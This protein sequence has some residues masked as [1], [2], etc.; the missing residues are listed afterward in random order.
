MDDLCDQLVFIFSVDGR[1]ARLR[2]SPFLNDLVDDRSVL[3]KDLEASS[4]LGV[5]LSF[6]INKILFKFSDTDFHLLLRW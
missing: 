1:A 5:G 2:L 4:R 3:G 6:G